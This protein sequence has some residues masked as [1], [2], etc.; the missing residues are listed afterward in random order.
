MVMTIPDV[1]HVQLPPGSPATGEPLSRLDRVALELRALA[2]G[3]LLVDVDVH[4]L[5]QFSLPVLLPELGLGGEE[6]RAQGLQATRLLIPRDLYQAL[7][8]AERRCR[9]VLERHSLP[10]LQAGSFRYVPATAWT[11][12]E[13]EFA[14]AQAGM[15]AVVEKMAQ[16]YPR[17]QGEA[18]R[19]AQRIA[20][21]A[22]RSP[23]VRRTWAGDA[24]AFRAMVVDRVARR[25]P[26]VQAVRAI[27]AEIRVAR[28]VTVADLAEEEAR[29]ARARAEAAQAEALEAQARARLRLSR[30][31]EEAMRRALLQEA[32]KAAQEALTPF[33]Q[34]LEAVRA[35]VRQEA[36][37][38]LESLRGQEP[39]NVNPRTLQRC[40]RLVETFRRLALLEDAAL[41]QEIR[42]VARAARA[43]RPG[44]RRRQATPD[45]VSAAQALAQALE[46]VLEAARPSTR[47]ASLLI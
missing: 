39:G 45:D 35:R 41:E 38:I 27:R 34:Y 19:L 15:R 47:G 21:E 29:L 18:L 11:A 43:V 6:A 25:F 8:T 26:E 3:G 22:W 46:G 42:R 1:Q 37:A 10:L 28:L 14:Q 40:L 33:E 36:G 17:L 30:E 31:A 7:R 4:G 5:R 20:T 16:D 13:K 44:G 24:T 2:Q 12:F 32:R 23:A 9:R